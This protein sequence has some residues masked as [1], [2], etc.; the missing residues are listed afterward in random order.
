MKNKYSF[1][2]SLKSLEYEIKELSFYSKVC[3]DCFELLQSKLDHLCK[4]MISDENEKLWHI[5]GNHEEIKYIAN[6]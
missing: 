2:L 4:F 6:N 3:C 1:L 5:W